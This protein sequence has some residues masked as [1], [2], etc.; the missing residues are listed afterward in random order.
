MRESKYL[1][2]TWMM[3][4]GGCKGHYFRYRGKPDDDGYY[5]AV[6]LCGIH[7]RG[8]PNSISDGFGRYDSD[9]LTCIN[10]MMANRSLVAELDRYY[11]L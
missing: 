5:L 10:R 7:I 6:S 8:V 4:S 1:A 11:S 9:C 3:L 2:A